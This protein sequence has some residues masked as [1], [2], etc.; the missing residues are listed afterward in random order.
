MS[1]EN[2][3]PIHIYDYEREGKHRERERVIG[4]SKLLDKWSGSWDA[5]SCH[6]KVRGKTYFFFKIEK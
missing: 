5:I 2:I 1:Y 3:A 4:Q 6:N